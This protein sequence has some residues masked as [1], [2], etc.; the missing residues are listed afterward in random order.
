MTVVSGLNQR[1]G[2]SLGDGNGEHTR[3]G[4]SWLNGVHPKKTEGSDIKN[5]T[6]ADQIAAA[7]FGKETVLPSIELIASEIDLVLGGQCEGATA[8]PT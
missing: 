8:A 4:A 1:N 2:E 5:G 6:T 7:Q 3:A